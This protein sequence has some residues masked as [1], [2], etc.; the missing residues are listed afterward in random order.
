VSVGGSRAGAPT[1]HT[2]PCVG[3]VGKGAGTAG[4]LARH[5]TLRDARLRSGGPSF[6]WL[7]SPLRRVVSHLSRAL[8]VSA[9]LIPRV[10]LRP[11]PTDVS[12]A[13]ELLERLQRSGELPPQKLQALQRVL[14]SRFC[15]A[16]REVSPGIL[17]LPVVPS[18]ETTPPGSSRGDPPRGAYAATLGLFGSCSCLGLRGGGGA[19]PWVGRGPETW[20]PVW[21]GEGDWRL[22]DAT[23]S[24]PRCTSSSMTRWTS[25]AVLRS[26]L[27]PRPR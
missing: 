4:S 24:L 19:D 12:R 25:A 5:A 17:L 14:Q 3:E 8:R 15:S 6:G 1:A 7:R 10:S 18:P 26:E 20:T 2:Y 22:P 16:I 21:R 9:S 13:V 11:R 27:M 23:A